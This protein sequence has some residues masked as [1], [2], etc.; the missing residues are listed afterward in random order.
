MTR[1]EGHDISST[2]GANRL[3]AVLAFLGV[4]LILG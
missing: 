1:A 3:A 4:V 2:K